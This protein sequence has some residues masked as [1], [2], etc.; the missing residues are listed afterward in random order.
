MERPQN[1]IRKPQVL[2]IIGCEGKNQETMYFNRVMKLINEMENRKADVLF[3]Y[4]EPYGGDPRCVVERTIQKSIGKSNKLSVFDFD[5]KQIKYEEA[6]ELAYENKIELGYT[7]FCFDL[8]IILHKTDCFGRVLHQDDYADEVRRVFGLPTNANIKKVSNVE[9]I[10]EQI[11]LEDIIN[12]IVRADKIETN[13][14]TEMPNYTAQTHIA[15]YNN[16]DTQVHNALKNIFQ[17]VG[18]ILK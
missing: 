5:G 4:A 16:P 1:K 12:A 3:D 18:I 10:M 17:K 11:T 2:Y 7:N 13:N 9:K 14:L 6:I 15:Y 8:W